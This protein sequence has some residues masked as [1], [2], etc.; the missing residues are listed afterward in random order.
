MNGNTPSLILDRLYLGNMSSANNQALLRRLRVSHILTICPMRP[1]REPSTSRGRLF[2]RVRSGDEFLTV[3]Q[4]YAEDDV[5]AVAKSSKT[6]CCNVMEVNLLAGAGKGVTLMK[7][8]KSDEIMAAFKADSNVV[9]HKTT[10]GKQ[11][12]SGKDR[13]R[14]G[15]GGRGRPLISRGKIK[16]VDLP[17][18][19]VP[20]FPDSD[21]A[22]SKKKSK[23]KG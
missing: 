5:C 11:K 10:G 20:E 18:P 9:L 16:A 22:G 6:L 21:D 3:F 12:L 13:S 4:V 8:D 23:R 19:A 7:L 2:G 14:V 15:R 1:H 17:P